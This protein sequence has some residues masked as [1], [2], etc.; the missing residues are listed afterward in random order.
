MHVKS[1]QDDDGPL[2]SLSLKTRLDVEA[3]RLAMEYLQQQQPRHPIALLFPTAKCQLIINERLLGHKTDTPDDLIQIRQ[4]RHPIISHTEKPM[5]KE[6][7]D[8]INWV[9]HGASHLFHLPH[10]NFLFKMCHQ[11]LPIGQTLHCRN[12]KYTPTCP[13]CLLEPE[14]Q[15]HFLQC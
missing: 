14:T 3:D 11:H 12:S 1:H 5:D 15:D 6:I 4:Y 9:A 13:G 10:H 8:T 2:E 7:L